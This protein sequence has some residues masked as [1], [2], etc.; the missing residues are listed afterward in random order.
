MIELIGIIAAVVTAVFIVLFG[1][2]GL[3]DLVRGAT[4]RRKR[5]SE[6]SSS[7]QSQPVSVLKRTEAAVAVQSTPSILASLPTITSGDTF[8]GRERELGQ[9]KTTLNDTLHGNGR[10][11]ILAGEP[12]IGKTRIAGELAGYAHQ[13]GFGVLW[14]RCYEERGSPAYW[15]W[16]QMVRYM[17][18]YY[19]SEQDTGALRAVLGAGA[20][21]I[22]EIVPDIRV[23]LPDLEPMPAL[24]PEQARFR[25]FDS[26]TTFL[27]NASQTQP[28]ML[29]LD[30]L[31]WADNSTLLLL[32]YFASQ[33]ADCPVL[34]VGAYRD[35]ELSRQHP[36]TETLAHL[37]REP[38]YQRLQVRGLS[39]DDTEELIEAHAAMDL[40]AEFAQAVYQRTEGNP[41]Y[42]TELIRLMAARGE[43]TGDGTGTLHNPDIPEGVREVVA[44]RLNR[45]SERC[46]ETL[47]AASVI[48]REFEF[49]VLRALG[50]ASSD[51]GLL[52]AIEEALSARLI[53]ELPEGRERYH[54]SHSLVQESLV[55]DLSTG[56]RARLHAQIGEALERTYGE[57]A[58]VHA[59]EL[60]LHFAQAESV[61]GTEKLVCATGHK[62]YT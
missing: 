15:P 60:A 59:A 28:L 53:E 8:V 54:F 47:E 42:M 55:Q 21:D 32:Q 19:V 31:H 11:V 39:R 26:I 36:L 17:V 62:G 44:Q 27:K 58:E 25:L 49:R 37:S 61:A 20:A 38:V 43:L 16:V 13:S 30:D 10:L 4:E 33:M 48:G 45:L 12:G 18:R 52:T 9:L 24:E 5:S 29:F 34:A 2:R 23:K 35:V 57:E 56:R 51:E 14:G 1:S 46:C 6:A 3:V 7:D 41:F 50:V 22:A 40:T